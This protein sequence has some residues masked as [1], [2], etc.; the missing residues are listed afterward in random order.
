M[1]SR[2]SLYWY[3]SRSYVSGKLY[4]GQFVIKVGQDAIFIDEHSDFYSPDHFRVI[5][6]EYENLEFIGYL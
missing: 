6:H 3:E 2:M 1:K 5:E 4:D